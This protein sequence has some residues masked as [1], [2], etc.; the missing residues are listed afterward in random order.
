MCCPSQKRKWVGMSTY[1]NEKTSAMRPKAT[2]QIQLPQ[3]SAMEVY[4][5]GLHLLQT[6]LYSVCPFS[7]LIHPKI[8]HA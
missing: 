4:K 6:V 3:R 2:R 1:F 7:L 8:G 5:N